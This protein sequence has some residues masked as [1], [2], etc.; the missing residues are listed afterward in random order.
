ML[1]FYC[2]QSDFSIPCIYFFIVK[3]QIEKGVYHFNC[4]LGMLNTSHG[5]TK[6]QTD[7]QDQHKIDLNLSKEAL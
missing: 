3:N 4:I 7:K 1:I 6:R 5:E 2:I